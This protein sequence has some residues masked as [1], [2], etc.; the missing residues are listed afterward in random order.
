MSALWDGGSE[1]NKLEQVSS[2]GQQ[3]SLDRRFLVSS[4][5]GG[6]LCPMSTGRGP[7]GDPGPM[8]KG[9]GGDSWGFPLTRRPIAHFLKS[10]EEDDV[11]SGMKW[12]PQVNMFE[13]VDPH[14]TAS[15]ATWEWSHGYSPVARHTQWRI[16]DFPEEGAPTLQGGANIRFCQIFPKTA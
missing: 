11:I 8:S 9:R 2:D 12:V 1:V 4:I 3:M 10:R 7:V 14:A 6:V 15:N 5:S 13:Q 16:Q